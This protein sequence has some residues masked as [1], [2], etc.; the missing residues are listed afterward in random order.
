MLQT[1]FNRGWQNLNLLWNEV[2][3]RFNK[4]RQV[5]Q[6]FE[7]G[8]RILGVEKSKATWKS[9]SVWANAEDRRKWRVRLCNRSCKKNYVKIDTTFEVTL[10]TKMHFIAPQIAV[11]ASQKQPPERS[12]DMEMYDMSKQVTDSSSGLSATFW[13]KSKKFEKICKQKKKGTELN[14]NQY[15][16]CHESISKNKR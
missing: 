1:S 10:P 13:S 11:S 7:S 12:N 9:S 6:C 2:W 14:Q 5:V 3:K 8:T 4:K 16:M 15:Q